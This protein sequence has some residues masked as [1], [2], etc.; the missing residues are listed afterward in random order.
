MV[1]L[2]QPRRNMLTRV[3]LGIAAA[4]CLP[5][6]VHAQAQDAP[7]REVEKVGG[8]VKPPR[9]IYA[10]EPE[11]SGA[12]RAAGYE[13]VSTLKL[14]VGADGIPRDIKVVGLLGMGLDEN[15]VKTV[16]K[17]RFNPAL[18]DGRPVAVQIAVEM[19]FHLYERN[20]KSKFAKAQAGDAKAQ[21]ELAELFL[22]QRGS[23]EDER[24]GLVYLGKAANQGLPRAQFLMGEHIAQDAS[25]DFPKA[26]MWYTLA[27]R[28]GYKESDN[29]LTELTAKMTPEQLQA[30]VALVDS[31]KP[32]P[33]TGFGVAAIKSGKK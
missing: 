11:F 20:S 23:S 28:G 31:W 27:R 12:A 26:Y 22:K 15:A 29:A 6:I 21:L 18:K 16:Q 7:A 25:A 19:D 9:V 17:W 33:P 1:S 10:P 32:V 14:V 13:G 8:R 30:G 5:A 4:V 2:G 3:V 24:L